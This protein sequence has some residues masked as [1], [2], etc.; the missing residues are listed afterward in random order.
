MKKILPHLYV[1]AGLLIPITKVLAH[2]GVDD[3]HVDV[4]DPSKRIYVAIGVG[5]TLVLMIAWFIWSK[6]TTK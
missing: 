2:G 1:G 5:I 6:R 4:A 3:G